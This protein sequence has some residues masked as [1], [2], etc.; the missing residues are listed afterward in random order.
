MSANLSHTKN[1]SVPISHHRNRNRRIRFL[2]AIDL[3]SETQ[4][5]KH[6]LEVYERSTILEDFQKYKFDQRKYT[7][8]VCQADYIPP[9]YKTKA[10]D[11]STQRPRAA[12]KFEIELPSPSPTLKNLNGSKAKPRSVS[13][14][15]ATEVYLDNLIKNRQEICLPSNTVFIQEPTVKTN[16]KEF[17]YK[18]N[19]RKQSIQNRES[20]N[21]YSPMSLSANKEILIDT[22]SDGSS[23]KPSRIW[24]FRSS[25][26][27]PRQK[28]IEREPKTESYYEDSLQKKLNNLNSMMV[29]VWNTCGEYLET[30]KA[31]LF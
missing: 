27:E 19:L 22:S 23:L 20:R 2:N 13:P 12:S 10:V 30:K 21:I 31:P 26:K 9:I 16:L 15:A 8:R 11:R 14:L 6:S 25:S 5:R 1:S 24:R 29:G 7:K 28:S 18:S 3:M 4:D 17:L